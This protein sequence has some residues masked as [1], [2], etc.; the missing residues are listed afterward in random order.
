MRSRLEKKFDTKLA[1]NNRKCNNIIHRNNRR[2][3]EL[4]S[5]LQNNADV[6][7]SAAKAEV[8]LAHNEIL[9]LKLKGALLLD[10]QKVRHKE[11]L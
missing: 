6:K 10:Q 4:V 11:L 8:K 7:L 9:A 2:N 5:D 3:E 1:E